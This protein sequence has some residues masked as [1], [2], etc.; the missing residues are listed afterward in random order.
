M[1][2]KIRPG[3]PKEQQPEPDK[4]ELE[5]IYREHGAVVGHA[6]KRMGVAERHLEDAL[7][8]V[9]EIVHRRLPGYEPRGRLLAWLLA[10]SANVA[11]QYRA[12]QL[13]EP[14]T[15]EPTMEPE[16]PDSEAAIEAHDLMLVLLPAIKAPERQI[17]FLLHYFVGLLVP[18]IARI[19]NIPEGTAYTRLRQARQ[20]FTAAMKRLQAQDRRCEGAT[21][22]PLFGALHQDADHAIPPLPEGVADRVWARLQRL[23]D[24][25]RTHGG[26]DGG[27]DGSRHGSSSDSLGG[28]GRAA[29]TLA[30]L[31]RA[32]GPLVGVVLGIVVGALWD[33]LH[34]S[35]HAPLDARADAIATPPPSAA[36]PAPSSSPSSP[37]PLPPSSAPSAPAPTPAPTSLNIAAER[38]LMDKASRALAS[39]DTTTALAVVQEHAQ[40]F[41]GGGRLA[42]ERDAIWISA[43]IRAGRLGEAH[44][45][46]DRFARRYP[47]SG[48]LDDF[49]QALPSAPAP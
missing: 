17:V 3:P 28:T 2:A 47:N 13:R 45:R 25:Q 32:A 10:I 46:L 26:G 34:R 41:H 48:R 11:K 36:P 14:L 9:F 33:P 24:V 21:V 30:G 42:E 16:P 18:E 19:L 49:R 23:P 39:G 35:P 38:A 20:E 44:E 27:D 37:S 4:P 15:N 6:L 1:R 43:L 40:G 12:K 7:H 8:D 29:P 31:A 5:A 22:L